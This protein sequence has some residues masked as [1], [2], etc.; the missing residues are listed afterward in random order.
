M[1]R[2]INFY[3]G[4]CSGKSTTA[5]WLFSELKKHGKN[6]E[7]VTEY[8]KSWAIAKKPIYSF[9]QVYITGKQ[10]QYEYRFL[11]NGI[12]TIITDSPVFLGGC[13][14]DFYHPELNIGKHIHAICEEYEMHCPSFN[15]FL[16]RGDKEYVT[17][18][19]YQTKD[20]ACELDKLIKRKLGRHNI[21]F[22]T[23]PFQDPQEILKRAVHALK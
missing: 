6:V 12:D 22:V 10:M 14:A 9:D 2:R 1:I 11:A 19:R 15:V 16:D 7:L 8:V 5:A 4:P 17:T 18:G 13:Y 21:N 20:Q 3:G 23:L